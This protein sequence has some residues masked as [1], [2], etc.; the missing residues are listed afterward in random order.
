MSVQNIEEI[1]FPSEPDAAVVADAV[2]AAVF[3]WVMQRGG[4][5]TVSGDAYTSTFVD[6]VWP[7]SVS[8]PLGFVVVVKSD[9]LGKPPVPGI[10][11][12]DPSTNP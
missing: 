11:S 12:G 3:E 2:R 9:C 4:T 1:K 6:G 8:T 7:K 10:L 5:M